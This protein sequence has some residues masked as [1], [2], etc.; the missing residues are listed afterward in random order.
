MREEDRMSSDTTG[1]ILWPYDPP[2]GSHTCDHCLKDVHE[3]VQTRQGDWICP[4]CMADLICEG[5]GVISDEVTR[6][7][8]VINESIITLEDLCL[9][10]IDKL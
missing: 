9:D 7:T 5:C 8:V 4:D 2:V 1:H 6:I 10:C 3:V